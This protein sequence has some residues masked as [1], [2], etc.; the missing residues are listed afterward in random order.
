MTD[1]LALLERDVRVIET[2]LTS[3]NTSVGK[4]EEDLDRVASRLDDQEK[5]AREFWQT[6]WLD[7]E[8]RLSGLEVKLDHIT[9]VVEQ[10]PMGPDKPRIWESSEGRRVIFVVCAALVLFGMAIGGGLTYAELIEAR[11]HLPLP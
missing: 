7:L 10:P 3:L 9:R 11:Q 2:R 5:R 1:D 6:T 4:I 8:R